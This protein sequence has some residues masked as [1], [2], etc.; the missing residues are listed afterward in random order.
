MKFDQ[1]GLNPDKDRTIGNSDMQPLW[2]MARHEGYSLHWDGL[3]NSLTEVVLT[4]AIGDGATLKTLPV[5]TC[6]AWR[7]GW[8]RPPAGLPLP[9]RP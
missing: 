5:G 7:P 4:G 3:N 1:L 6:T 9:H 2:N 8:D